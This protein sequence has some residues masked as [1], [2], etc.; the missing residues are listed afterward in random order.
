LLRKILIS[1][2][3]LAGIVLA[4]C[5][6]TEESKLPSTAPEERVSVKALV[7][8]TSVNT[9]TVLWQFTLAEKWHLYANLRNDSGF[10]PSVKLTLPDGW[11]AGDLQWPVPERHLVAGDI[12]DHV[13]HNQLLLM[14]EWTVPADAEPG[15]VVTIPARLDWLICKDECVPGKAELDL[16]VTVGTAT[17]PEPK[18]M[19]QARAELPVPA[20]DSGLYLNWSE[21]KVEIVVHG[22]V[23]LE[24]YPADDCAPLTDIIN[25]CIGNTDRLE[26]NLRAKDGR[27]GPLKGILHQ[28][29]PEDRARN[30]IINQP[31][32][33]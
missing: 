6:A 30:W 11:T 14:Q 16:E 32:G 33:G 24:F 26:I 18:I 7:T 2:V 13:Y 17:L 25:D 1:M 4:S 5:H 29:F 31:Y 19:A 9:V 20:P 28:R 21:S 8:Q 15:R 23:G 22:A 12:L 3:V 27:M 10:P